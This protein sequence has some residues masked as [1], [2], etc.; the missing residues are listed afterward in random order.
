LLNHALIYVP[1]RQLVD[2]FYSDLLDYGF[3]EKDICKFTSNSGK[4]RNKT[5]QDNSCSKGFNQIIITNRDFLSRHQ[6]DLPKVGILICDEVHTLDPR[7][8][9]FEFI[10]SIKTDIK[11]G[12]T[13]TVPV[14]EYERWS[15]IG[16]FGTILFTETILHL[17][18][19]GY[20]APLKIFSWC[21]SLSKKLLNPIS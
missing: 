7:S 13:G 1:T 11:V 2:Q 6:S 18:E 17:Q 15:L 9:S 8:K 12:F 16:V 20:L 19:L 14:M 3:S 10:K 5:F 21:L 4:K